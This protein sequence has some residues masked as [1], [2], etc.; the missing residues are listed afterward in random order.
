MFNM[1]KKGATDR[2]Y[3]ADWFRCSLRN[4]DLN[5]SIP[6]RK[7]R[8]EP[9]KDDMRRSNRLL[10]PENMRCP[11]PRMRVYTTGRRRNTETMFGRMKD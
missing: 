6:G 8:I 2:G 9:A 1:P 10:T 7:S 4:K 11:L 3:G 5:P